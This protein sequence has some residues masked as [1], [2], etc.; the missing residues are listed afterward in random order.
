MPA[1]TRRGLKESATTT[2]RAQMIV[3]LA[4]SA[5]GIAGC[6]SSGQTAAS[7]PDP[8]APVTLSAFVG[9]GAV[10]LA[11][12]RLGAGPVLLTVANQSPGA[13]VLTLSRAGTGRALARTAPI[14][15]G[16]V[17]QVKLDLVRGDYT[18]AAAAGGRRTDAQRSSAAGAA[19][20][21]VL[22]VGAERAS[23]G[24]QLLQP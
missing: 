10:H 16:G 3:I 6:G 4:A 23:S 17:T 15:P 21:T 1:A 22:H 18:V 12:A 24:D 19:V 5:V 2:M 7:R 20:T 8:P 9:P 13:T 11:P 14:N